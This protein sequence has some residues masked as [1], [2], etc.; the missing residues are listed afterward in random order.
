VV[1][2]PDGSWAVSGVGSASVHVGGDLATLD[3]L[4]G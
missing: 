4:P 2:S 3:A 1:R